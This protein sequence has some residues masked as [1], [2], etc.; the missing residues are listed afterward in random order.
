[1]NEP[2]TDFWDD[3]DRHIEMAYEER[4]KWHEEHRSRCNNM[5]QEER[6][7]VWK[8]ALDQIYINTPESDSGSSRIS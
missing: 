8:A 2:T 5:S 1:M 3:W 6:E 7:R 4:V